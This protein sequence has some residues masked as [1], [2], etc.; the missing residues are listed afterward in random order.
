[1]STKTKQNLKQQIQAQFLRHLKPTTQ[2]LKGLISRTLEV[3]Q[4]Y[5]ATQ[6]AQHFFAHY[7]FSVYNLALLLIELP[8]DQH[9]TKHE[10]TQV[11]KV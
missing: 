6:Y 10:R 5:V 1:V 9:P 7:F 2:Q 4:K 11:Y 3:E 8:K